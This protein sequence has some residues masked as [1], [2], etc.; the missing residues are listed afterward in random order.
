MKSYIKCINVDFES[1][2]V[3]EYYGGGLPFLGAVRE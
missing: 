1:S 2:R 3:E